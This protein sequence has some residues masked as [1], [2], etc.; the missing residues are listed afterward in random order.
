MSTRFLRLVLLRVLEHDGLP[1]TEGRATRRQRI[2][3]SLLAA[4]D[5]LVRQGAASYAPTTFEERPNVHLMREIRG[6]SY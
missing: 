6:V 1:L 3:S 5:I 4:I 2:V